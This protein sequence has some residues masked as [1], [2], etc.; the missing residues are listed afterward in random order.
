MRLRN[1]AVDAVSRAPARV[2]TKLLV[3]FLA[4]VAL[5]ILLG[6]VGLQV[7]SGMSQRT[8]E[9]IEL[10]RKIAAY[11]QVQ[12]DTTRQL[13]GVAAALLSEDERELDA[14]L[15]QLSQFGYDLDRLQHVAQDEVD[16]LAEVREDYD[17]FIA[18]VT[19]TVEWARAGQV[20]QA[21]ELRLHP[22][23]QCRPAGGRDMI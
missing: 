15:R 3:A 18:I 21:R 13:Y 23:A 8:E 11:R 17:R 14:I 10:Q 16:L 12:H 7:L 4:M 6:A 20:A 22:A 2:Q 9:L 5:L 1:L 19:G